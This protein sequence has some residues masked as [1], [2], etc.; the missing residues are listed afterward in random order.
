[1]HDELCRNLSTQYGTG[2]DHFRDVQFD[3]TLPQKQSTDS[4]IDPEDYASAYHKGISRLVDLQVRQ[5]QLVLHDTP[6]RQIYVDGGFAQNAVFMG[7][8]AAGLPGFTVNAADMP[9]ASALGAAMAM[10][11]L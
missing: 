1:M 11:T 10:A 8:L 4:P 6:V 3:V 7:M 5:L 2:H 9:Q